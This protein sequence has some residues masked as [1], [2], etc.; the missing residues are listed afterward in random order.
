MKDA[1]LDG[2]F[3]ASGG[4]GNDVIVAVVHE[5][6]YLNFV[7][8]HDAKAYWTSNGRKTTGKFSV[9]LPAGTFYLYI[10]NKFSA[11]ADKHVYLDVTLSFND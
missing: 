6:E 8:G 7:N 3:S 9:R 1:V 5:D 2:S 4:S 10:G 11:F